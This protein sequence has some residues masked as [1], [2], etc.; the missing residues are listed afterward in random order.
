LF[1]DEVPLSRT[2]ADTYWNERRGRALGT[3]AHLVLGDAPD[4]VMAWAFDEIERLEQCWSR[5]RPDSELSAL[6]AGAGEWTDVSASMLLALTCAADLHRQTFGHFDPTVLEALERVGYDRSFELIAPVADL[7]VQCACPVPGFARVEIDSDAARVRLPRGV[8]LDL[9]GVGKGLAADL[10]ARGALDR[11][12]R[13]A[14]VSLG[15]DQ[16]ARGEPPPGGSWPVPVEHPLDETR[17]AFVYPL[18]D[19]AIVTSTRRFRAW[20]RCGRDYHHII[21]PATGDS[22]RTR[23]VAVV[24]AA[25]DAWWA[26]GIAKSVLIAG[27]D[28]GVALARVA[29]VDALLFLDDG[30]TV[31]AAQ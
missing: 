6:N 22:A 7:E 19:G 12:A 26:E 14:F 20:R 21:D 5:F 1:R 29:G 23:V 15:G 10:V 8:R 17:L 9:G 31:R 4:D 25:R 16:R 18:V 28:E 11:G 24:A 2:R 27:V 30:S 13:S 3:T